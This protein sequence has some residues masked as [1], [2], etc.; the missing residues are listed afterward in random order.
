MWILNIEIFLPVEQVYDY[1]LKITATRGD[2]TL[3]A[4]YDT[5]EIFLWQKDDTKPES[6]PVDVEYFTN[7]CSVA[8]LTL[9]PDAGSAAPEDKLYRKNEFDIIFRSES[10]LMECLDLVMEDIAGLKEA[11]NGVVTVTDDPDYDTGA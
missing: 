5:D 4:E 7:V 3:P 10:L 1:R 6:D 8:D 9:R 11:I 2:G